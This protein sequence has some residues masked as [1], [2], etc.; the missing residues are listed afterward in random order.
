MERGLGSQ[1][2]RELPRRVPG[3]KLQGQSSR[4]WR[5]HR[6]AS[7]RVRT[8]A[9]GTRP[10]S[11]AHLHCMACGTRLGSLEGGKALSPSWTLCNCNWDD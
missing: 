11:W 5:P 2:F 1:G 10:R 4:V 8:L 9:S 3:V 6:L 7:P